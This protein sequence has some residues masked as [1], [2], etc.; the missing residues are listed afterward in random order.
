MRDSLSGSLDLPEG[1]MDVDT[2]NSCRAVT[3]R[4]AARA[5][6]QPRTAAARKAQL[7]DSL[8]AIPSNAMTCLAE[9]PDDEP[10]EIETLRY[11]SEHVS[12]AIERIQELARQLPRTRIVS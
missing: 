1:A 12:V 8:G 6:F 2:P 3:D 9:D 11:H 7:H 5:R 10:S 4:S